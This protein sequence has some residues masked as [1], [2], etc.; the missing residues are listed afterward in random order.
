M[1]V[2]RP[3]P[4]SPT[5]HTSCPAHLN[6][7]EGGDPPQGSCAPPFLPPSPPP[8]LLACLR[9]IELLRL[10]GQRDA[11]SADAA[12]LLVARGTTPHLFD[13]ERQSPLLLAAGAGHTE[14]VGLLL[15]AG[16]PLQSTDDVREG[17]GPSGPGCWQLTSAGV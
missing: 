8:A 15:V 4:P 9:Q 12:V 16:A 17:V 1:P 11:A 2:P 14:L 3:H 13:E 6:P 5:L 10:S 7:A